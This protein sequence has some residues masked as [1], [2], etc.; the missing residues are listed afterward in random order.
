M[1]AQELVMQAR[2]S[3]TT[4]GWR[5]T[6]GTAG[7]GDDISVF[8]I[9]LRHMASE[10]SQDTWSLAPGSPEELE[11]ADNASRHSDSASRDNVSRVSDCASRMSDKGLD[12][13]SRA[14]DTASNEASADAAIPEAKSP[15]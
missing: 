6:A 9:P 3:P 10:A 2:G 7:S 8:V 13:V 5:T 1:A 12:T 4:A 11:A 15:T 14:S